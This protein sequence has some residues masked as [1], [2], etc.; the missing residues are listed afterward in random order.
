M[1]AAAQRLSCCNSGNGSNAAS[2][3]TSRT[4]TGQYGAGKAGFAVYANGK[5]DRFVETPVLVREVCREAA[6]EP[7]PELQQ[8]KR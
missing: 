2:R 3:H 6:F 7:F 4:S 8:L 5:L 1:L